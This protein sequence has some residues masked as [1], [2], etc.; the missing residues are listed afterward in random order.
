MEMIKTNSFQ[1]AVNTAGDPNNERL[2]LCLPGRLDTKDYAHIQS[3]IDYFAEKG[4]FAVS[5]DPPGTWESSDDISL[6]TTPNYLIAINEIIAHYG[7]RPT[8]TLG[9][10][11]GG[12]MAMLAG[13]NNEYVTHIAAVMSHWG[14]S[15]RPDTEED[16]HVSTRDIPPGTA[17]TDERK[18]FSLPMTY[19]DDLTD[20]IGLDTCEKP[21]LLFAGS[22]D[23]LVTPEDVRETF[24]SAAEPKL[25]IELDSEHDYR[26]H[27][28]II[29]EV[30][31]KVE[32]FIK[33]N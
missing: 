18:E 2:M 1:L 9:H 23:V 14:P 3:H 8:V 20:Y 25:F 30:N 12:T 22:Q 24:D 6:Y 13:V 16:V 29:D 7:N 26:L 19:F 17:R 27:A 15:G 10:S 32:A 33:N 4:F 31:M 5:F 11:R 28:E 21:K